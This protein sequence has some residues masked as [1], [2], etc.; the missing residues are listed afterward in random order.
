MKPR[1]LL[2]YNSA[3]RDIMTKIIYLIL[4]IAL[5]LLVGASP[6]SVQASV[7]ST[8]NCQGAV[9]GNGADHPPLCCITTCLDGHVLAINVNRSVSRI[10]PES[11]ICPMFQPASNV[12]PSP[13]A[14]NIKPCILQ[15]CQNSPPDGGNSFHC[16]NSLIQEEPPLGHN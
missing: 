12:K 7:P 14:D 2:K 4:F 16:R 13:I 10:S 15:P 8:I 9:C 1:F 6:V 3:M 5:F 11:K